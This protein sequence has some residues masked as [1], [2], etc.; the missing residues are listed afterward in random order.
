MKQALID[1]TTR[2]NALTGWTPN[3]NPTGS[4]KYFPMWTPIENSARVAQVVPVGDSFPIA[5]P[6][7]WAD[8][9]DDVVADQWYYNTQTEEILMVPPPA[10][11]PT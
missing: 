2:V 1:P 7:F 6:F 8:C 5:P 9:A 10:P 4:P 11:M 3:P